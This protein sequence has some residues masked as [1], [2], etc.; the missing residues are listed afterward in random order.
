MWPIRVFIVGVYYLTPDPAIEFGAIIAN[1]TV[2]PDSPGRIEL[3]LTNVSSTAQRVSGRTIRPFG[4][5]YARDV[6]GGE[7]FLLRTEYEQTE[8]VWIDED[9][10]EVCFDR[11]SVSLAP[12]DT[13]SHRY[14]VLPPTTAHYPMHTVPPGAATYAIRGELRYRDIHRVPHS[15]HSYEAQLTLDRL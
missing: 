13:V 1:E 7:W 8:C 4:V 6:D 12:S 10:V 2:T 3:S 15:T 11:E 5:V 14:D 9:S